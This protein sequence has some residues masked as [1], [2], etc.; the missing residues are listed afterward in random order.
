[1]PGVIA[2]VVVSGTLAYVAD[3]NGGLRIVDVSDP[4]NPREIGAWRGTAFC[5]AVA[6]Q[7]AY[8]G[9]GQGMHVIDVSNPA[10]PQ[11]TGFIDTVRG[12]YGLAAAGHYAYVGATRNIGDYHIG[13]WVMDVSD[14]AHPQVTGHVPDVR[15]F[16]VAVAGN[17]AYIADDSIGLRIIDIA[18]P[19]HPA[20]RQFRHTGRG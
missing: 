1:M 10:S 13:L 11:H 15:P 4:A 14:P 17:Y 6:G 12:V 20:G 16:G 18:D 8:V 9:E 5:V 7:Y 2:K 3:N 19:A